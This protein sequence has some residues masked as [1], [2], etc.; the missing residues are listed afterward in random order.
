MK[1]VRE[2]SPDLLHFEPDK[3][4]VEFEG[5]RMVMLSACALGALR[6]ELIQTLGWRRARGLMKRFGHAAGLADGLALAE[7]FPDASGKRHMDL[8]PALHALEGIAKVV[9]IPEFTEIDLDNGRYHVEAYWEGSFEAEQHLEL[10]GPSDEPVCWT[11]VGYALGHSSAAAGRPTVVVETECRAMGHE[12]CR[13]TAALADEMPDVVEREQADYAPQHLPQVLEDLHQNLKRHRRTL[14]S[15]EKTIAQ[16]RSEVEKIRPRGRFVGDSAALASALDTAQAVA[17]YDATVLVLGESGTGKE[18]LARFVHEQSVRTGRAFESVNCSALPESLQEAELFGYAKGA[19]TGAISA[20]AG[21]FEAAHRGTLFLDEIGDLALSAQTKIL[22]ALQEGEIKR[23]GESR[24]RQLDTRIIAATHRD[25]EAM[26][27]AKT[28]REDLFYRL[29]VMTIT[30][31]PLRQRGNDVLLLAEH[32]LSFYAE[33]FGK[34]VEGFSGRANRALASHAW[35]GNVRE[36]ENVVQRAVILA[37][38]KKIVLADLPDHLGSDPLAAAGRQTSSAGVV[39]DP[40]VLADLR[41]MDNEVERML[42]A[43]ELGGGNRNRAAG[44]L[45]ISRTTLWRRMKALG[46]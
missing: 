7:R 41:S 44:F 25:L 43:L 22:R 6:R 10:L 39:E 15:K 31:P 16:L 27:R 32:F 29:S 23:L 5:Y 40:P 38:G 8:G 17:P 24:R 28:F 4:L 26:V 19:F 3:G 12:R 35:P 2:I 46:I 37:R 1:P 42:R 36:L 45:G 14:R 34:Q 21:V 30:L 13:F 20:S 33:R 9:R 11:L 18:L